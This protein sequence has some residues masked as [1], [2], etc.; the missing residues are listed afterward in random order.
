MTTWELTWIIASFVSAF[1]GGRSVI[2]WT[3]LTYLIGWPVFVALLALGWK[4]K[5][6]E[7]R[8]EKLQSILDKMEEQSKPKDYK[9][10]ETVDDLFKQLETN[11]Q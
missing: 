8:G 7:R 10:F 1:I 2:I 9:D 5:V 6:W 11:K 4:P 3:T